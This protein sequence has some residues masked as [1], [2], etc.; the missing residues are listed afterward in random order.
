MAGDN[1]RFMRIAQVDD[2]L[3]LDAYLRVLEAADIPVL[4]LD[5]EGMVGGLTDGF[6]GRLYEVQVP[7]EL[8]AK[9]SK[10]LAEE[11][12]RLDAGAKEAG[13]DAE[14]EE[15]ETEHRK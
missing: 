4:S 7:E 3:T 6:G 10:L 8:A 12:A 1:R 9:A 14:R 11:Q 5:D 2:P 15:A 13:E